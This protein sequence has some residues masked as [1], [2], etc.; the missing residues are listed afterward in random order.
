VAE[1]SSSKHKALSLGCSTTK[2][3]K[4]GKFKLR[5]EGNGTRKICGRRYS[6]NRRAWAKELKEELEFQVSVTTAKK[7]EGAWRV[8]QVE[9]CLD[10]TVPVSRSELGNQRV[11]HTA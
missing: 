10:S 5:T 9:R 8:L 6:A 7:K 4:K 3:K 11:G 1:Y 2:K